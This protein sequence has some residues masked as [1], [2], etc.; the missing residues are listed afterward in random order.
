VVEFFPIEEVYIISYAVISTSSRKL[1]FVVGSPRT[2]LGVA[3]SE[4]MFLGVKIVLEISP[5]HCEP[6]D[7]A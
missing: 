6:R 3:E 1:C 5:E 4:F 2:G 7:A